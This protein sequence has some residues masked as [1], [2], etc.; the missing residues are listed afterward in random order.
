[1]RYEQTR[2]K[3]SFTK[4]DVAAVWPTSAT[5]A[6]LPLLDSEEVSE[7]AVFSPTAAA[8]DVPAA[9]GK[10]IVCSYVGLLG[11]FA[12]AT[13]ASS[14]SIYMMTISALFLVAYFTVPWLFFRQEPGQEA[15]PSFDRFM[16]NGMETLTGHSTGG[17]ALV[18][19]MIV[20]VL[21]TFGVLLMAIAAAVIM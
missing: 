10:L 9:V 14:Y 16:Q 12:L 18:Q 2:A 7:G 4:V 13:V 11:A 5:M 15:R 20:P 3:D 17:A 21:L 19:M 8:P 6:P 1:M